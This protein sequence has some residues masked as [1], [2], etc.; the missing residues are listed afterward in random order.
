VTRRIPTTAFI[1]AA[2]LV[3]GACGGTPGATGAPAATGS[4]A[5]TGLTEVVEVTSYVGG[6]TSSAPHDY[7]GVTEG[8][9]AKYKL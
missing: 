3:I 7:A 2:A 4:A 1:V 6:V 9:Y 5:P 8:I